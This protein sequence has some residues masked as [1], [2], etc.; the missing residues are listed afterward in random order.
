MIRSRTSAS[1]G[2][3][4]GGDFVDHQHM[5]AQRCSNRTDNNAAGCCEDRL[6]KGAA[7]IVAGQVTKADIIG[8]KPEHILSHIGKALAPIY[9][10]DGVFGTGSIGEDHLTDQP[11][12]LFLP[13]HRRCLHNMH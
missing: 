11:L 9:A 6:N 12:F 5:L 13:R 7:Q 10:A 1:E 8:R 2:H 3:F 4:S